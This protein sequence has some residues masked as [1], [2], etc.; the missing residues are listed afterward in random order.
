MARRKV[1]YEEAPRNVGIMLYGSLFLII[2]TFF[3]ALSAM[4]IQDLKKQ[5]M[6]IGSIKGGFGILPG[7]KS[8]FATG[9][10]KNLFPQSPPMSKGPLTIRNIQDT[11]NEAGA[12]STVTVSEGKLGATI[13]IRSSILFDAQ[14]EDLSAK[15]APVLSAIARILSQIDN[16]VIVTGHTDSIP[17]ET[18]PYFSNLGLS[19]S[20][21]LAV[22]SF[23]E[24]KGIRPNRLSAYGM[25]STRPLATNA[26]EEGRRLNRRVEITIVG[27]L[28]GE[29]DL[30][31]LNQA[32]VEWRKS[33]FYKGFNFELEEQ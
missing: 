10:L 22:L 25:G 26:T 13:A 4:S 8:P 32:P 11:L 3:V 27:D 20:R 9:V 33:I 21:A 28:P 1:V 23:L 12:V 15:S 17:V 6:A 18:P 30:K 19:G 7:G 14:T 31:E 2:L 16:P 24:K 5:K 29:V